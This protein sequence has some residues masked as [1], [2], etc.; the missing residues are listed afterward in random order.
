MAQQPFGDLLGLG[1]FQQ[2]NHAIPVRQLN[3]DRND[4]ESARSCRQGT[5]KMPQPRRLKG[6]CN[7]SPQAH[8]I[9]V[10]TFWQMPAIAGK[11]RQDINR[12]QL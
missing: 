11:S 12:D 7:V 3:P 10:G 5:S 2:T 8:G 6:N 4:H 1:G 9:I